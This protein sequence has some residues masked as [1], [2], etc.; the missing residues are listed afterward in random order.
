MAEGLTPRKRTIIF[1]DVA[2]GLPR[3]AIRERD[4]K[5]M[6][7]EVIQPGSRTGGR[8][9]SASPELSFYGKTAQFRINGA[10]MVALGQPD[11]IEV[12]F[13]ADTN[14]VALV[15]SD[16]E[17]AVTLRK[18]SEAAASRY[19]GFKTLAVR[20]GLAED[21]RFTVPITQ[22]EATGMYVAS[23]APE[24]IEAAPAPRR[25]RGSSKNANTAEAE[26]TTA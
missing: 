3:K 9:S 14:R 2:G 13:D 1:S 11:K 23:L 24:T 6:A 4:H 8:S 26:V 19:F 18:D 7:F 17:Y 25:A 16:A 10:A 21:A 20:A 5:A 22:D 15:P 12:H